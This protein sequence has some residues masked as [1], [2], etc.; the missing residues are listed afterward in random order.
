MT[1]IG[2]VGYGIWGRNLT[3]S[4]AELAELTW[5]CDGRPD[6]LEDAA[7]RYSGART[8]TSLD[9]LL[10][11]PEL[12]A[13]VVATTASGHYEISKRALEA[14]KHVFV[15]KPPAQTE[16]QVEDLIGTAEANDRVLMP[17]YLLL[18]HPAV[19]TL[20]RLVDSGELGEVLYLYSNRVNLGRIRTD[21]NTVSSLGVHDLSVI[22]HL[23]DEEPSECWAHG[24]A[25]LTRGIEDVAFCYLRFPSGKSAHM[26]L[27][28]LDQHKMRRITVVGKEKM[29]VFDDMELER[30][31]TIYEKWP[32]QPADTYGEWQTRTGDI[33]SPKIQTDEPLRL[34]CQHF[35]ALVRGEGDPLQAARDGVVVVRVLEQLQASLVAA[36]A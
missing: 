16:A 4:F 17:G 36:P 21:E 19:R 34:E 23:L 12:D 28:W 5:V 3:R 27:S 9:D 7:V 31:V 14:G 25:Y 15:E 11:D 2:V 29:V 32:E 26:H 24:S 22:L 6:A 35:L 33:Y 20:K 1:R 30:K 13:I 18:Y 10:S 8:T